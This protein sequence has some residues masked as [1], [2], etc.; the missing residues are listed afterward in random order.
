MKVIQSRIPDVLI[1]EP[2][3][4]GDN[5]GY[6]MET[7][8]ADRYR[9]NSIDCRFVQDNFS[10]SKRGTL[11]GLHYQFPRDQAKLVQVV[12]GEIFDVAVD[13]RRGSPTFGHWAGVW[14][15]EA[16][17]RQLFIPAGFAHG[18]AVVSDTAM[19]IYKCSD[20]YV[21]EAEGGILWNDPDLAIDWPVTQPILSGK[22]QTFGPLKA[23]AP[24]KLPRYG[25]AS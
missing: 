2:R 11:R 20:V 12:Q 1:I 8:H 21:P 17:H 5:R 16:N 9:E 4:F 10:Y 6:F 14:L 24:D 22:D 19:F 23:I 25:N 18:F 13:I 15:S 7:F 3:V